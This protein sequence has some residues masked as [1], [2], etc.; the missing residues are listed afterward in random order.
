MFV[1]PNWIV[2]AFK[3]LKDFRPGL[4]P[5]LV[6]PLFDFFTL[7]VTEE[8]FGHRVVPQVT[9][10]VLTGAQTVFLVPTA[11]LITAKLRTLIRVDDH[12]TFGPAAPHSHR[13]RVLHQRGLHAAS[14]APAHDNP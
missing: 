5:C 7:Q 9:P 11:E 3:V 1:S 6:N 2:E 13:Q 10:S 8:R 14:H 4:L 12:R